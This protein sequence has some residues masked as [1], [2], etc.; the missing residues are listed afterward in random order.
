L[1]DVILTEVPMVFHGMTL[2]T[3][4]G[5]ILFHGMALFCKRLPR[6][7]YMNT[8]STH[9]WLWLQWRFYITSW[10]ACVSS[11]LTQPNLQDH[12]G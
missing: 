8:W 11:M 5:P 4:D 9:F 6:Q 7:L 1:F 2:F 10:H 12:T 3:I